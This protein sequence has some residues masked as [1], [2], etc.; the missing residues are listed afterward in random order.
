MPGYITKQ[1]QKYQHE[2]SKRP[3]H[4]PYTSSPQKYGEAAQEPI[5]TD[6][7][8]PAG[9]KGINRIHKIAGRILY[10]ARSIYT[11]ILTE[12]PTLASE[13]SKATA[14]TINNIRQLL[15]YLGTYPDAKI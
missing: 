8:K 14:Q 15:D 7:C 11:T 9:P 5:K 1:L 10:Y 3:Q 6:N 12:L 13:Q 2:I 4:A